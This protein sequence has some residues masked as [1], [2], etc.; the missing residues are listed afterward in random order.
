MKK[1]FHIILPIVL[2]LAILLTT[3]WYFFVYDR[4]LTRDI[5]LSCA[6]Y[7]EEH[8]NHSTAQWFYDMA[9]SQVDDNDAIAI[10]MATMYKEHGN[11]TKAEYTLYKAIQDGGGVDLYIT[12]SQLYVE[13]DKLLDAANLLNNVTGYVK[14]ELEQM[15]PDMPTA[16][17]GP[18][19]YSVQ[20]DVSF[21]S[22]NG[23]IYVNTKGQYPSVATDIYNGPI[24]L[25]EGENTIYAISVSPEGL[26]SPLA[27]YGYTLGGIIEQ[28]QFCDQA[29]E[30][31]VR[32]I[33]NVSDNTTLYSNDLW[34]IT[35]F[36][37]P[38]EATDYTDLKHMIS[39]EK[40]TI[41]DG[42]SGQL[43]V[44]NSMNELRELDLRNMNISAE[45]LEIIGS[46]SNLNSLTLSGCGISSIAA[47]SS[48]SSITYLDLSNNT[49]RDISALTSMSDLQE[50]NMQQ[51][52]LD[53]L[54]ALAGCVKLE[55]L[56]V[57]YNTISSLSPIYA[58]SNIE[59]LDAS[60]N[61]IKSLSGIGA[62]GKL[63]RL[64]VGNNQLTD[65][66]PVVNC[67]ELI[68]LGCGSNQLTDISS[69][70]AAS[71][72]MYLDF[73]R[74]QVTAL[75]QFADDSN[76]VTID[77]SHN[78]LTSIDA[79]AGLQMLNNVYMDYNTE[80]SS[81]SSLASCYLLIRVDVYGTKVTDI[82][83]LTANSVVVNYDPTKQ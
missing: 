49:I 15:R 3:I 42:V 78:L 66:S 59:W 77:G 63:Q 28:I 53:D 6:R 35:E 21:K 68:D 17:P 34:E 64:Y 9:Y 27:I 61:N 62:M 7:F 10:E 18:D 29:I 44:L 13:Q 37:V 22:E 69:L 4:E 48:L 19:F 67:A 39:L 54:S 31:Q 81:I 45:E 79:L 11:Y 24:S 70:G 58:L 82:D 16:S 2:V 50:V 71:G 40:L 20:T 46:F 65:I 38:A 25:A 26:V 14:S 1:A 56:N 8:G 52:A 33:L 75:P 12:L 72:L 73:S 60:H 74:N 5:M 32:Q 76:L 23:T 47:L 55:T 30:A 43:S 36:T 80:L 51:N 41:H 83:D 57:S